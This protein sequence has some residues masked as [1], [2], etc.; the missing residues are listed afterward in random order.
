[1]SESPHPDSDAFPTSVPGMTSSLTLLT[2][3]ELFSHHDPACLALEVLDSVWFATKANILAIDKYTLVRLKSFP[4]EGDLVSDMELVPSFSQV[5]LIGNS[6]RVG[7]IRYDEHGLAISNDREAGLVHA[8]PDHSEQY[9]VHPSKQI[10]FSRGLALTSLENLLFSSSFDRNV[11]VWSLSQQNVIGH[12]D[13]AHSD[14][15]H[16][17]SVHPAGWMESAAGGLSDLQFLSSPT[18]ENSKGQPEGW[19]LWSGGRDRVISVWKVTLS[20]GHSSLTV[21]D[22]TKRKIGNASPTPQE[23]S[24]TSSPPSRLLVPSTSRRNIPSPRR[25]ISPSAYQYEHS[26]PSL[27]TQA[28]P[29]HFNAELDHL[30]VEII[31]H[32]PTPSSSSTTAQAPLSVY[33]HAFKPFSSSRR[34]AVCGKIIL[35]LFSQVHDALLF[36]FIFPFNFC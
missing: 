22:R 9:V 30:P 31:E 8:G 2:T 35:S 23:T 12:L 15:I 28:F 17:L 32:S 29:K 25:A 27:F 20:K 33:L 1:V 4:F 11:G 24:P 14:S 19:V 34:C 26:T 21:Y 7:F 36:C 16:C 5:W 18:F 6:G 13:S 3:V 10:H